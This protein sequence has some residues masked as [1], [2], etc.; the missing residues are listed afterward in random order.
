MDVDLLD[1]TWLLEYFAWRNE[2]KIATVLL[3]VLLSKTQIYSFKKIQNVSQT[4]SD[5]LFSPSFLLFSELDLVLLLL[6]LLLEDEEL[7]D[8]LESCLLKLNFDTDPL[9]TS[10]SWENMKVKQNT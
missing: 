5:G 6:L 3:L 10:V 1:G 7:E 8:D 2:S 9:E 4:F